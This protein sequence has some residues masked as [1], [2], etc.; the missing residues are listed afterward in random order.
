MKFDKENIIT[1]KKLQNGETCLVQ[2]FGQSMVPILKSGQVVEVSPINNYEKLEKGDVVLCRVGRNFYLHKISRISGK[3]EKLRFQISNNHGHV[4][5][6]VGSTN[7]Y[8]L[9]TDKNPLKNS[10]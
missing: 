9:V 7:I 4:N 8:G 3:K 10:K 2:G 5:G 6:T 1:A